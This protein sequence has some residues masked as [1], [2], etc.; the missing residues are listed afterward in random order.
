MDNFIDALGVLALSLSIIAFIF[1]VRWIYWNK[2]IPFRR[3]KQD[4]HLTTTDRYPMSNS[5]LAQIDCRLKNCKYN[6][7]GGNCSNVSPAIVLN[8]NKDNTFVCWSQK[9]LEKESL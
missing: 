9:E 2:L 7:G 5:Q 6:T 4:V 8:N 1:F 3:L